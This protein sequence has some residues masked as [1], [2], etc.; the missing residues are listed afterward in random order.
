VFVSVF[1]FYETTTPCYPRG[2]SHFSE[3]RR[4]II[5]CLG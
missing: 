4:Q 1:E 2:Y 5:L 3:K